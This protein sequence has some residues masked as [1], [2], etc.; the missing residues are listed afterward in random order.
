MIIIFAE[1]K[2]KKTLLEE[3]LLN[4]QDDESKSDSIDD[5]ES[6]SDFCLMPFGPA[7]VFASVIC[8]YFLKPIKAYILNFIS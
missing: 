2:A 6:Q 3:K 4:S 1:I 8:V 7:L 5:I